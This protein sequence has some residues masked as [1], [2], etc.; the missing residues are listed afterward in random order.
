MAKAGDSGNGKLTRANP[1]LS[2][3]R[4]MQQ[5]ILEEKAA[6][7]K[8]RARK[9][10]EVKAAKEAEM[11]VDDD[12][13]DNEQEREYLAN[14]ARLAAE[15]QARAN[16]DKVVTVETTPE[17]QGQGEESGTGGEVEEEVQRRLE[18]DEG[19]A[20]GDKAVGTPLAGGKV[21]GFDVNINQHL[22]DLN[23]RMV[24]RQPWWQGK[25]V[26]PI[27]A[28]NPRPRRSLAIP[29]R[30]PPVC[31]VELRGRFSR[32]P[33]NMSSKTNGLFSRPR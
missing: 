21:V 9:A 30:P 20:E 27:P 17:V 16:P 19:G 15:A 31:T 32:L 6:R 25:V 5:Q 11:D 8:E 28:L 4:Q 1:P 33:R 12:L 23:M 22:A 29:A 2:S 18:D 26:G 24:T 13:T 3:R 7:E 14:E 10:A